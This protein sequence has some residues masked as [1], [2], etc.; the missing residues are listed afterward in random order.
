MIFRYVNA[1]APG[2]VGDSGLFSRSQLKHQIDEG[3]LDAEATKSTFLDGSEYNVLPYIV[4]DAAFPLGTHP[5]KCYDPSP[6]AGSPEAK[7]NRRVTNARRVIERAF[8][9]LKG[10]WVFCSKNTFWGDLTFTKSAI[11]ASCGLLNFLELRHVDRLG[12][13]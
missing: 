6:P 3:L 5:L 13:R 1:G 2:C 10:R 12:Q 4:G 8:G 11:V 7:F 9:R